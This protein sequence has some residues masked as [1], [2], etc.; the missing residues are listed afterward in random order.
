MDLVIFEHYWIYLKFKLYL[1]KAENE[2]NPRPRKFWLQE[3]L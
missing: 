3:I 1:T 2:Q